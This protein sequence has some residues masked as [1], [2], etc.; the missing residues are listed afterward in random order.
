[1]RNF[2]IAVPEGGYMGTS[3][4]L[5]INSEVGPGTTQTIIDE[6][7]ALKRLR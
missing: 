7:L 3:H 5:P 4:I 1:M 2:C 6:Q